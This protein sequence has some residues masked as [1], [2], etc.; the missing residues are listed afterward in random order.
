[1]AVIASLVQKDFAALPAEFT[2]V[3]FRS[4]EFEPEGAI[5]R[6]GTNDV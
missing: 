1:M 2:K 5:E 3:L 6:S 4:D